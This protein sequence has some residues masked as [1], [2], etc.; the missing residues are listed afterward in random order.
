[1]IEQ[2]LLDSEDE[3]LFAKAAGIFDGVRLGHLQKLGDRFALQLGD[4]HGRRGGA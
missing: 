3:I 4:V 1:L 2:F